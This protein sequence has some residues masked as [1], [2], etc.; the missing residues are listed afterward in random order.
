MTHPIIIRNHPLRPRTPNILN[1][2]IKIRMITQSNQ[3]LII[4]N[5]PARR[6]KLPPTH[7]KART[8]QTNTAT[9][10]HVIKRHTRQIPIQ[11]LLALPLRRKRPTT[12]PHTVPLTNL[13]NPKNPLRHN[14]RHSHVSTMQNLHKLLQ[15]AM[16]TKNVDRAIPEL[17]LN[18]RNQKLLNIQLKDAPTR[19]TPISRLNN[20]NITIHHR[21]RTVNPEIPSIRN[22]DTIRTLNQNLSRTQNM[23]SLNKRNPLITVLDALPIIKRLNM[24]IHKR[25]R[26]VHNLSKVTGSRSHQN[27]LA[28]PQT[29]P[30][31]N[32]VISMSMSD[33]AQRP[34]LI[35]SV[36]SN[37]I[38]QQNRATRTHARLRRQ[39]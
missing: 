14:K 24:P 32:Q 8:L 11:Q 17:L 21:R 13:R 39:T 18:H 6:I 38:T 37:R 33:H 1:Q 26:P 31:P 9:R 30:Q 15:F 2:T 25:R 27:L 19:R 28:T 34:R 20:K 12:Q 4:A 29:P 5:L 23:I 3:M 22:P 36:T 10:V 16:K 35:K 7:T